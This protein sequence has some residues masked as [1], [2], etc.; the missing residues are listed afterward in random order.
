[1]RIWFLAFAL[2]GCGSEAGNRDQAAPRDMTLTVDTAQSPMSDFAT[3]ADLSTASDLA[4]AADLAA[5]RDMAIGP[6]QCTMFN[7]CAKVEYCAFPVQPGCNPPGTC[8]P[9]PQNCPQIFDPVCGCDG[10]TYSNGCI[11]NMAGQNYAHKGACP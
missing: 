2:A 11:A 3:A 1:M 4:A 5:A 9:R 6:G 8:Q 10:K 7:D